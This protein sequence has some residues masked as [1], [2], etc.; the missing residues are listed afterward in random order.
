MDKLVDTADKTY[1]A[2]LKNDE[3]TKMIRD[4]RIGQLCF[5]R[6]G[7]SEG[8][9]LVGV[10][11]DGVPFTGSEC[12]LFAKHGGMTN[13]H[14]D[15]QRIPSGKTKELIKMPAAGIVRRVNNYGPDG[16]AKQAIV[17]HRGDVDTVI[18]ALDLDLNKESTSQYSGAIKTLP[19]FAAKLRDAH[20]RFVVVNLP[21]RCSYALPAR[22]AHV[23]I[24]LGLVESMAWHPNLNL[25]RSEC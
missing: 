22:C 12:M 14:V 19:N 11:A 6:R 23:F 13:P 17:V 16:P 18:R 7:A 24:T 25:Q 9:K 3:V 5:P 1:S 10:T 2:T 21:T 20:V 15:V 4:T 8:G